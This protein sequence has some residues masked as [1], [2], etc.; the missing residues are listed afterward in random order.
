MCET[1]FSLWPSVKLVVV[2]LDI[3][4]LNVEQNIVPMLVVEN[5]RVDIT[6]TLET[7]VELVVLVLL[8]LDN[9]LVPI[10]ICK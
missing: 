9:N 10:M 6:N 7:V 5:A 2:V 8:S 1:L 4:A 3:L